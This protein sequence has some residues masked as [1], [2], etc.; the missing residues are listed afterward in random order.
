MGL[1]SLSVASWVTFILSPSAAMTVVA[2][3]KPPGGICDL[4][5][6]SFQVPLFGSW[7]K[8]MAAPTKQSASVSKRVLAFMFSS[9]PSEIL[10]ACLPTPDTIHPQQ[11]Q[12]VPLFLWATPGLEEKYVDMISIA[13]IPVV[14]R[15]RWP[16]VC[17]LELGVRGCCRAI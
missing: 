2:I 13:A 16:W 4:A 10:N 7:A 6:L 11:I 15:R 3:F 17:V 8:H 5:S 9:C 14:R 12:R 1:P